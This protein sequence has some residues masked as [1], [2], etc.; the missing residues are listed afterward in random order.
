MVR[1]VLCVVVAGATLGLIAPAGSGAAATKGACTLTGAAAI[2]PGLTTSTHPITYSFN[3]KL[4]SCQNLGTAKSGTVSASGSGTGA[5]SGNSTSGSG[6]ITWSNGQR[7]GLSFT[8]AGTG[9]LVR[10][11]G[12]ITSGAFAGTPIKAALLFYTTSPQKCVSGGLPA[13]SFA[14]PAT[15]GV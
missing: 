2:S 3:G 8:T 4:G 12:T 11:T 15:I 1:K 9:V 7:S 5:C 10:V 6:T 13:A 14:G